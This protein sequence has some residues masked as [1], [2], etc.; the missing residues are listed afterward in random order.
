MKISD[1]GEFGFIDAIKSDTIVNPEKVVVGIGDDGAVYRTTEAM[2]QIAVIDTMV[3]GS[4]FIIGSTASWYDVGYKAV[5]SNL[6]DIAAMGGMPTHIVLSAAISPQMEMDDLQDLY[7]G[8]KHLCRDYQVNIL[9]GDTVMSAGGLVITVAA[10]GEVESGKAICRSGARP[11]D[12]VAVSH[13]VGDS[14]GGLDVLLR[15]VEG[16]DSLKKRHR[17]PEPQV[18]LGRRLVKYGGHS[19]NDISDGLASEANEIARASQADLVLDSQAIPVSR[20]LRQWADVSR[21]D[22]EKFIFTGGEDYELL[23]TMDPADFPALQGECPY[24][25][26]IGFVRP[27]PGRVYVLRGGRETLLPPAGWDHFHA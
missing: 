2:D 18:P 3:E 16:Y 8:I 26:P 14:S 4:H 19:I 6:S 17:L 12:I 15:G 27:G 5:A 13:T 21:Q 7:D 20:E 24:V 10:F 1:I 23:F 9:G 11:G 22:I 25:T